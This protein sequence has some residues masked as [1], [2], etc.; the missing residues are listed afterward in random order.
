MMNKGRH[1]MIRIS[2]PFF[3]GTV[4]RVAGDRTKYIIYDILD[5]SELIYLIKRSDSAL[6]TAFDL[7]KF[8]SGVK[9]HRIGKL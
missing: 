5:A 2:F 9:L 7:M 3:C 4:L 6:M 8:R 1:I